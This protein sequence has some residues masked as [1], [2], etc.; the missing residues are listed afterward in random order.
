MVDFE[1]VR[2]D[3]R[4][5]MGHA[6]HELSVRVSSFSYQGGDVELICDTCRRVLQS[7]RLKRKG[8]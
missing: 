8:Q 6:D 7:E 5:M 3:N 2:F 4:L 1:Q